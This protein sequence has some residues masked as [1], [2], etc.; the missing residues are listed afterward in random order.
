MLYTAIAPNAFAGTELSRIGANN[1][2]IANAFP[3]AS[4]RT[5][6]ST[7]RPQASGTA[8]NSGH[9]LLLVAEN[10]VSVLS[11]AIG[12]NEWM[13]SA[14]LAGHGVSL[15]HNRSLYFPKS[16]TMAAP[17]SMAQKTACASLGHRGL[18]SRASGEGDA[19]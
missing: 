11:T 13:P 18:M 9:T 12:A 19:T 6:A 4:T 8:G 7:R 1:Q 3:R 17:V 2:S 16:G 10:K 5:P 15:P 14:K